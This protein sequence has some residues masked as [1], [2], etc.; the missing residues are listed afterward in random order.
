MLTVSSL[1]LL[2][3]PNLSLTFVTHSRSV[4][5]SLGTLNFFIVLYCIALFCIQQ[6][7]FEQRRQPQRRVRMFLATTA[8]KEKLWL[9]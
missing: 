9:Y 1:A 5:V 6:L 4:F 3:V 8:G 2:L 7:L